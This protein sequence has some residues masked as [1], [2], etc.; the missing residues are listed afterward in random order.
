MIQN[1]YIYAELSQNINYS[2]NKVHYLVLK[3]QIGICRQTNNAYYSYNMNK[4][5]MS[6]FFFF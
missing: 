2:M 3:N 6:S 4:K 5:K 1:I